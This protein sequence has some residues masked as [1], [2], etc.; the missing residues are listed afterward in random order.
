M[1]RARPPDVAR[2][3]LIRASSA[4]RAIA[5]ASPDDQNPSGVTPVRS[6]SLELPAPGSD[7][8]AYL[9]DSLVTDPELHSTTRKLYMDGHYARAV[10]EAFKCVNNR[11]KNKSGMKTIDGAALMHKVFNKDSPILRLNSLRSESHQDEQEG[12]RF[13]FAGCMAGIRNPRAH[14]HLLRDEPSLALEMLVIANHL[15]H[16]LARATRTKPRVSSVPPTDRT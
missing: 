15:T 11:V 14:E 12:Y 2:D 16:V 10:E 9:F 7:H 1:A 8:L 6:K 5:R 13:V 4:A 3:W